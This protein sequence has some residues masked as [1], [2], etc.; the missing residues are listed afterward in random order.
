MLWLWRYFDFYLVH[1]FVQIYDKSTM[2]KK[3]TWWNW[4]IS[5]TNT[6]HLKSDRFIKMLM[7]FPLIWYIV[8]T[9]GPILAYFLDLNKEVFSNWKLMNILHFTVTIFYVLYYISFNFSPTKSYYTPNSSKCY[10]DS[11]EL[12][13]FV[14][15]A[16]ENDLQ[17]R[18]PVHFFSAHPLCPW[19]SAPNYVFVNFDSVLFSF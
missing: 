1:F 2:H 8:V 19:T 6:S 12:S 11:A 16:L 17:P 4:N 13:R 10:E 18:K 3:W 5:L 7:K 14:I 15:T 9:V